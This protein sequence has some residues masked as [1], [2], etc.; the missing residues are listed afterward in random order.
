[1]RRRHAQ[2]MQQR[3]PAAGPTAA[4]AKRTGLLTAEQAQAAPPVPTKP[5]ASEDEEEGYDFGLEEVVQPEFELE[6]LRKELETVRATASAETLATARKELLKERQRWDAER[7]ELQ[8]SLEEAERKSDSRNVEGAAQ[9][10]LLSAG[11]WLAELLQPQAESRKSPEVLLDLAGAWTPLA[12]ELLQ[13]QRG[14]VHSLH[15]GM[16]FGDDRQ[17]PLKL[18]SARLCPEAGHDGQFQIPNPMR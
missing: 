11:Q 8:R 9:L 5:P 12:H 6:R 14:C 16:F 2:V 15:F 3:L 7:A 18:S 4:G 1:M 17:T 10:D 13:R